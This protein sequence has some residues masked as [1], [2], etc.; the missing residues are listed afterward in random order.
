MDRLEVLQTA[1]SA[2]Q[3][4]FVFAV[5]ACIGSLVNVLVY[6]LPRGMSVVTP[7]SRCPACQTRLTWRENIPIVGWIILRGRC[8]FCRAPISREY[9]LIEALVATMFAGLFALWF[10]TPPGATLLGV[11]VGEAA[12]EWARGGL[13]ATWPV[14]VVFLTLL[15][16]LV[17][18]TIIDA[19]TFTIPLVL[20]WTPAAVALIAHPLWAGYIQWTQGRLWSRAPGWT[21][22]IA[23]PGAE[24]WWWVGAA[25]GG[26]LGLIASNVLLERGLIRRSFADYDEWERQARDAAARE[27]APTTEPHDPTAEDPTP[28]LKPDAL[29]EQAGSQP[30]DPGRVEPATV[31]GSTSPALPDPDSCFQHDRDVPVAGT[32]VPDDSASD[33]TR[34]WIRYPYARREMIKELAFLAPCVAFAL[35]GGALARHLAGPWP[36]NFDTGRF[37]PSV[38]VPLWLDVLAGVLMGYLIG[39]GVVWGV[40]IAGSLAFGK[41]A[42]GLGDVHLMGAVGACLGWIDA[43]MAF[44]GAAFVALAWA[45]VSRLASGRLRRAMPYGPFLAVAT[46]LV[47]LFKPA[48]ERGL[49]AMFPGLGPVSLP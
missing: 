26:G 10:L 2:V 5:G 9:P 35:V 7:P 47:L 19:R 23:T 6:R 44:F 17:A 31:A 8:R 15:A 12:P 48:I 1:L 4:L 20:T 25:L 27:H 49:S 37:E 24:G 38:N 14:F 22:A 41:E 36:F 34:L 33:P 30:G 32:P 18:T 45:V 11:P 29:Q 39:G 3:L 16:C 42:M 28:T 13:R 46:L 40:R 21:W 43:V